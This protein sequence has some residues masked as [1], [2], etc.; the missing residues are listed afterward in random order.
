MAI[1]FKSGHSYDLIGE[2]P[3]VV[4]LSFGRRGA[5]SS[6]DSLVFQGAHRWINSAL[7]SPLIVSASA[8]S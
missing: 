7:Y 2:L 4:S 1:W 8:L 6:T 5:A 3:V